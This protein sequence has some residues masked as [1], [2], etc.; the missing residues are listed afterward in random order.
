MRNDDVLRKAKSHQADFLPSF[1]YW[2]EEN[3]V[4]YLAF[5]A[6]ALRVFRSGRRH[7]SARRIAEW[8]C[9]DCSVREAGI[10]YK[11]NGDYVPDMARLF[12][13]LHPECGEFFSLRGRPLVIVSSAQQDLFSVNYQVR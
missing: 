8:L 2:L 7:Y 9:H 3:M 6:A 10:D 12:L 11:I 5:D 13:R 1:W 4:I